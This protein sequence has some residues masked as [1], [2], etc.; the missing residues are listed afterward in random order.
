MLYFI[1]IANIQLKKSHEHERREKE[2]NCDLI[3]KNYGLRPDEIHKQYLF[4]TFLIKITQ[5]EKTG[6]KEIF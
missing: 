4:G 5:I 1:N 3:K 6:S 2:K